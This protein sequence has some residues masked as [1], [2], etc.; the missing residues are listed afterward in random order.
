MWTDPNDIVKLYSDAKKWS[1]Y[2]I[3]TLTWNSNMTRNQA[4][5][6]AFD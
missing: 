6:Q 5:G 4:L 2:D 3:Y 1:E